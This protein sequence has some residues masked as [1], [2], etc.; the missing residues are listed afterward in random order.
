MRTKTI[1][2]NT[3]RLLAIWAPTPR[4]DLLCAA[5]R[6]R[7]PQTFSLFTGVCLMQ[8]STPKNTFEKKKINKLRLQVEHESK[9]WQ[10]HMWSS[11][12]GIKL[13]LPEKPCDLIKANRKRKKKRKRKG[14]KKEKLKCCKQ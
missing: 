11:G 1:Q 12:A 9:S 5:A 14:K 7:S 2:H 8:P 4:C 10:L 3:S 6:M 13:F